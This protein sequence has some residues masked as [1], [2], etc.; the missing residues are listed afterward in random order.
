MQTLRCEQPNRAR[1]YVRVI[2]TNFALLGRVHTVLQQFPGAVDDVPAIV[3]FDVRHAP[4][5]DLIR[6]AKAMS[7]DDTTGMRFGGAV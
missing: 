2:A 4:V 1:S 3:P 7:P 5:H 6:R